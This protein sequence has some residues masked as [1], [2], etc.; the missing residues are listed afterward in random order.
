MLPYRYSRQSSPRVDRPTKLVA[1][2]ELMPMHCY[3]SEN[4]LHLHGVS[5]ATPTPFSLSA[6]S[7]ISRMKTSFTLIR[8]NMVSLQNDHGS[9][10]RVSI[11]RTHQHQTPCASSRAFTGFG[12]P[13]SRGM[14]SILVSA[15]HTR[16]VQNYSGRCTA[17]EVG[18]SSPCE[19]GVL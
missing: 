19:G 17:R 15:I 3:A 18:S 16:Q 12:K 11:T 10:I 7:A 4:P 13:A 6:A 14:N 9:P 5:N 8:V 1:W 2:S